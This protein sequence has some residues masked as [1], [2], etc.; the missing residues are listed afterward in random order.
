MDDANGRDLLGGELQRRAGILLDEGSDRGVIVCGID[1]E[2]QPRLGCVVEP[3][4]HL[5]TG[6]DLRHEP[7]R[8]QG[9]DR[10]QHVTDGAGRA[11]RYRELLA[12]R[13]RD[14]KVG[15][16]LK[17]CF[18]GANPKRLERGCPIQ[19]EVVADDVVE[20][21]T[22]REL[23]PGNTGHLNVSGGR[24][25]G[26]AAKLGVK[27]ELR[28]GVTERPGEVEIE[29]EGATHLVVATL[30]RTEHRSKPIEQLAHGARGFFLG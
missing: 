12:R 14:P 6:F 8:R 11:H 4:R 10:G 2:E 29:L 15:L 26:Q 21:E 5:P 23:E 1:V 17:G 9:V 27:S 7:V 30:C 13:E 22:K 20:V 16:V 25:F 24:D 18:V 28:V 3:R 19:F